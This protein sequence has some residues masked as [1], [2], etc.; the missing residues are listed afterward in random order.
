MEAQAPLPSEL[1]QRI[2]AI[3]RPAPALM[4]YYVLAAFAFG[5]M[6]PF[7]LIYLYFRYHTMRYT[8]D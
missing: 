5:P 4:K 3:T 6:L 2:S 1:D 8:F 7:A